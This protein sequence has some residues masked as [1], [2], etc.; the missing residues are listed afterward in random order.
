APE[1]SLGLPRLALELE[2][3][4]L[5]PDVRRD[6]HHLGVA[7][8]D[9]L[10]VHHDSPSCAPHPHVREES[11][12]HVA[13]LKV[14]LEPRDPATHKPAVDRVG[15]GAS[16][17]PAPCVVRDLRG[18]DADVAHRLEPPADPH[19]DGVAVDDPHHTALH[20]EVTDTAPSPAFTSTALLTRHAAPLP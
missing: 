11:S 9:H 10:R 6:R 1:S 19:M 18:V 8:T 20:F 3:E 7:A 13:A 2:K 5:V 16:M 4:L 15:S 14:E 12:V 17:A